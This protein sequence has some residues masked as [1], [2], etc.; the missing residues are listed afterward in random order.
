MV[1]EN[2]T[3]VVYF[4]YSLKNIIF[5]LLFDSGRPTTT[6]LSQLLLCVYFFRSLYIC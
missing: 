2:T 1:Y 4:L 5:W 3:N 6:I